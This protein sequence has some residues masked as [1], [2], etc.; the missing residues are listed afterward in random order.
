MITCWWLKVPGGRCP[1]LNWEVHG[2]WCCWGGSDLQGLSLPGQLMVVD[3]L[4]RKVICR[5]ITYCGESGSWCCFGRC[6]LQALSHTEQLVVTVEEAMRVVLH[7]PYPLLRRGGQ[8][9][10][11]EEELAWPHQ[12]LWIDWQ[13]KLKC[14]VVLHLGLTFNEAAMRKYSLG[15]IRYL[16]DVLMWSL[17]SNPYRSIIQY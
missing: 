2:S 4:L 17:D 12:L 15:P 13:L 8:L 1:T 9:K 10:C 16:G 6:D 14:G 3:A 5:P 11:C 7:K